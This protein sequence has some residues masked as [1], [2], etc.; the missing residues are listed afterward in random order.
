[1]WGTLDLNEKNKPH[2]VHLLTPVWPDR[3]D[4]IEINEENIEPE[5]RPNFLKRPHGDADFGIKGSVNTEHSPRV[6]KCHGYDGYI[7]EKVLR[8]GVKS[9]E[10]QE[11]LQNLAIF[12]ENLKILRKNCVKTFVFQSYLFYA[13]IVA[14][15]V[16]FLG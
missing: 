4:F 16:L 14:I 12:V 13:K 6:A 1:M 11:N 7:R 15:F 3:D 8:S 10:E 2:I 9:L 5:M